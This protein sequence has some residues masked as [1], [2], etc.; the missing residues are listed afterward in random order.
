MTQQSAPPILSTPQESTLFEDPTPISLTPRKKHTK[1]EIRTIYE[2]ER[3][4]REIVKGGWRRVALQLPDGML[5]DAPGVFEGL[6]EEIGRLEMGGWRVGGDA[7][8]V[9]EGLEEEIGRLEMGGWRVGGDE[10]E[11]EGEE[12]EVEINGEGKVESFRKGD[13]GSRE[14]IRLAILADTSYGSC[15]VDEIAAEHTNAEVV[16]HYGRA[17]LSPTARLPVLYVYTSMPLEISEVLTAFERNFE[18]E[19]KAGKGEKVIVMADL[20]YHS[21]VPLLLD[22]LQEKGWKNIRGTEVVHDPLA[23]IPNRKISWESEE[24]EGDENLK[25]WKIWH[26]SQPPTSLLLTLSSRIK[27]LLIYPTNEKSSTNNDLTIRPQTSRLLSRRYALL[28]QLSTTP[29]IGILINTLSLSSLLPSLSLLKSLIHNAG[30]KSYTFC[31]GKVNSAKMANFSEVGGWVVLGCWESS[32]LEGNEFYAP[33]VTPFELGIALMGDEERV[34]S[35]EWRGDFSVLKE[36]EQ[37]KREI[38]VKRTEI[39]GGEPEILAQDNDESGEIDEEDESEPPVYDF[40]TGRYISNSRPM[41]A[42]K[43]ISTSTTSASPSTDI[44]GGPHTSTEGNQTL[45]RRAKLDVATINGTAS[46]G[47]EFLRSQRTWTGLGSDFERVDGGG[48]GDRE[49]EG[50]LI[51]EGRRGVAR[52]YVVGERVV[53]T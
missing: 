28:T 23:P 29:I 41:K 47:A 20:T 43:S 42:S 46:P 33:V 32:L 16:I 2:V 27:E 44:P 6:E 18:K 14:K 17:C 38:E 35:G 9:F 49:G 11:G 8:G 22:S 37:K 40:R 26:I 45:A 53:R 15:C 3:T 51:E 13:R 48:D 1:E 31:V 19:A 52:G 5:G 50:G 36:E 30:K 25:D 12:R 7:P 10:K 34:W 39:D 24:G 21:H 4:A